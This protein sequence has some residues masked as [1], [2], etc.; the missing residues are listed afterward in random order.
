MSLDVSAGLNPLRHAALGATRD[1]SLTGGRVQ[2]PILSATRAHGAHVLL[3][4]VDFLEPNTTP[5]AS[6]EWMLQTLRTA[7]AEH[8]VREVHSKLVVLGERGESPPGFT[9]VALL[10]ESHVIRFRERQ[11]S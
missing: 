9:A 4:F 7:V 6:G 2:Q 5:A 1:S 10:D 11:A 3:D 8:G